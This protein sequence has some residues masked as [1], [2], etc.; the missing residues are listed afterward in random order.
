MER[1]K[2]VEV[3]SD[4]PF[5]S[6]IYFENSAYLILLGD[7]HDK[8]EPKLTLE[9]LLASNKIDV[10]LVELDKEDLENLRI[11]GN[12][13][14][15]KYAMGIFL[16]NLVDRDLK[17]A[18]GEYLVD[19]GWFVNDREFK[20][21]NANLADL[22]HDYIVW[23]YIKD[24]EVVPAMSYLPN[25]K[26]IVDVILKEVRNGRNVLVFLGNN[27]IKKI[28]SEINSQNGIKISFEESGGLTEYF[29]SNTLIENAKKIIG[30]AIGKNFRNPQNIVKEF[31]DYLIKNYLPK[32]RS[33]LRKKREL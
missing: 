15:Y 13:I 19:I 1:L 11:Y 2:R 9:N 6:I 27:H 8:M 10:L 14:A 12:S 28:Y 16:K 26:K 25:Y 3:K 30:Y 7:L 20:I 23:K 17:K 31:K 24:L 18:F 32:N 4:N 29:F 21:P 22:Y 5:F 33:H